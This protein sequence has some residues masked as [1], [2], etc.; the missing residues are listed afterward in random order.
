MIHPYMQDM[1][2]EKN[3]QYPGI[4]DSYYLNGK[5]TGQLNAFE[6]YAV[7]ELTKEVISGHY[8]EDIFIY[9]KDLIV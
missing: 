7:R 1:E 6:E 9:L 3:I 5:I 8:P 4:D 2:I